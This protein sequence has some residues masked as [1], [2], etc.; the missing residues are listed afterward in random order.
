MF[1]ET[2]LYFIVSTDRVPLHKV[3][4]GHKAR[5]NCLMYPHSMESRY[6][7]NYL[8]SGSSDFSVKLW[9]LSLGQPIHSFCVH[10]GEVT[11]FYIPPPNCNVSSCYV[12]CCILQRVFTHDMMSNNKPPPL[13]VDF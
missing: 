5:V 3:L 10:A 1:C 11:S 4:S 6:N 2:V 7:P 13:G 9:D 8:L 12:Y